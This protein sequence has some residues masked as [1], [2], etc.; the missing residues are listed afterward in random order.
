MMWSRSRILAVGAV[1]TAPEGR[2]RIASLF[3]FESTFDNLD[4]I[5]MDARA[6]MPFEMEFR[7]VMADTG[8]S[9]ARIIDELCVMV[10]NMCS[11]TAMKTNDTAMFAYDGALY[12]LGRY[13]G[14]NVLPVLDHVIVNAYDDGGAGGAFG[15]YVR[16]AGYTPMAFTYYMAKITGPGK[17]PLGKAY[18][19]YTAVMRPIRAHGCSPAVS[20]LAHRLMYQVATENQTLQVTIDKDLRQHWPGYTWSA[21]RRRQIERA[22]SAPENQVTYNRLLP[23][24]TQLNAATNLVEL[25]TNDFLNAE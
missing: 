22:V 4:A 13:G 5:D 7:D 8:W 2:A 9:K 18:D 3:A 20:N 10:T 19:F 21:N 16:I 11:D 24:Q 1:V 23:I 14:T 6:V 17:L 25:S 15:A 12:N